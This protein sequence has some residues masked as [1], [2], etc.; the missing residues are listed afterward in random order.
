MIESTPEPCSGKFRTPRTPGLAAARNHTARKPLLTT[1]TGTKTFGARK[2][3]G[4]V[5]RRRRQQGRQQSHKSSQRLSRAST[6][7][8]TTGSKK[9]RYIPFDLQ[10]ELRTLWLEEAEVRWRASVQVSCVTCCVMFLHNKIVSVC[11]LQPVGR[12]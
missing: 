5:E 1:A 7:L 6:R 3:S 10:Q 11:T 4:H 8:H 12:I 9:P 2:L